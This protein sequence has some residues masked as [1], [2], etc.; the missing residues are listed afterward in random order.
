MPAVRI[1]CATSS[2]QPAKP[3]W[4]TI[5]FHTLVD[6]ARQEM[7]AMTPEQV[8]LVEEHLYVVKTV[9]KKNIILNS[10]EP[11]LQ[12]EELYQTGCFA[13]CKAAMTYNPKRNI[14][15]S[16]YAYHVVYNEIV[17]QFRSVKRYCKHIQP[18][19]MPEKNTALED[20]ACREYICHSLDDEVVNQTAFHSIMKYAK[21]NYSGIILRGIEAIEFKMLGY[22]GKDIAEMYGV[23]VNLVNAWIAKARK[24]LQNDPVIVEYL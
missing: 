15:F 22:S 10:E 18:E 8:K 2:L 24:K 12:F 7:K 19:E 5:I 20:K 3:P 17:T 1:I 16:S 4:K 21:A 13:L 23:K 6:K 9:I 11:D 14:K